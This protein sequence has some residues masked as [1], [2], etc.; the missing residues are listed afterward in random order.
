VSLYNREI[1]TKPM[2]P[3]RVLVVGAT[4]KQGGGV[5]SALLSN[6]SAPTALA[7]ARDTSTQRAQ[8]LLK[9]YPGKV[10]L[11]QGD[12]NHPK[13][14][15]D[16]H[17]KGSIDS[18]FL[19]TSP[20][21][22]V[23]QAVPFI[24]AARDHGVKH[25]VFSSVDRGGEK[26][27]WSNPTQIQHFIEKHE[28]ELHLRDHAGDMAW[29]ILRPTAFLDNFNPGMFGSFF[30]SMW[31]T[32]LAP[33]TKLQL[34]ATRDIGVWAAKA[35]MDVEGFKG[36]AI[37]LAGDELTLTEAEEVFKG[38]VGKD[39]PRAWGIVGK[40]LLWGVKEVRTMFKFFEDEGYGADIAAL[41]QE[42]PDLRG[43][44]AWLKEESGWKD[45][46]RGE[47]EK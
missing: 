1:T 24:D 31:A 25:L 18:L 19:V 14:I 39:L 33:T 2:T 46:I 8:A 43:F 44:G 30:T 9:K 5:L 27:S 11:V 10:E 6:P 7:L 15:F 29:T 36:R 41:R 17:P 42:Q 35:I 32:A 37:S 34:V 20:P 4:G 13:A 22:E 21:K 45:Q 28:I 16:Q 3:S 26:K 38:V 23:A 12:A 47:G 40:G